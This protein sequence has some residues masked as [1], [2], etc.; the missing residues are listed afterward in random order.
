VAAAEEERF[1]RVKHDPRFPAAAAAWTLREG[2]IGPADVD[3]VAFYDKP[4]L[5]FTRLLESFVSVAPRGFA[6]WARFAPSWIRE[7]LR[8]EAEVRRALPGFRG[9]VLFAEH[10]ESHA[11]S[12]FYPSPFD[13]AAVLTMDGVGEWATTSVAAGE[14]RDLRLLEEIRYPHSLGLLYSAFT[15]YLGFR[16]NA[17]EYKVM[18]LAP[19]GEP[20]YADRIREGLLD[21]RE[22]GSFRLHVERFGYLTGLRMT[23][24]AFHDLIGRGPR[25]PD[26]PIEE[27]HRDVARSIQ[28]V[29]GEAMLRLSRHAMEVAGSRNLCLAGGVALNCVGNGRILRESGCEGLWIQPAAGD[30]G[31]ALGAALAVWHR[32][33]GRE[34]PAAGPGDGMGGAFLGPSFDGPAVDAALRE[35]GARPEECPPGEVPDRVAAL[36]A[37][38]RTCG[39]FQGRAEFGPRALGAR[40]ILADPRDPDMQRNLNLRVKERESFRPFAP[41]VL[42][43]RATEWFDLKGESPYMLLTAALL[44]ARRGAV[45]AVTHVDFS[46]RVQT[47]GAD[48]APRF[49]ALLE[50]F[51]R[52][53]GC[54]ILV[55]TSFN[56]RDEP[57]VL[58]PGD[59]IRCFRRTRLDV[60]VLGDRILLQDGLPAD[61]P[62]APAPGLLRR[63]WGLWMRFGNVASLPLL[64]VL[65]FGVVTPVALLVRLLGKDPLGRRAPPKA[66]YWI[67]RKPSPPERFERQF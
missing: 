27:F 54:P 57:M 49:R 10:H 35:A 16:V 64:A 55:N 61:P 34:R 47:V 13:R 12:A 22:D 66:S 51:E 2:G 48:A 1:S 9:R 17:D 59:A 28:E 33:L 3:L 23:N 29:T 6:G 67:A 62:P 43:E 7:R 41:A 56:G 39:W 37:E 63:A 8:V 24:R 60:L 42:R 26:D 18:G 4:V 5:K 11:A 52:R 36:L 32:Y 19:Y 58:T 50:A 65:Y 20:R 30:A 46:A 25:G 40:S 53:T 44:P 45:P 14:G 21:L 31:G 15:H 38:G